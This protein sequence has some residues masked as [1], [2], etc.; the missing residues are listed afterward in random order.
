MTN[1]DRIRSMSDEELAE[2]L[3]SICPYERGIDSEP[4]LG[5]YDVDKDCGID[6]HDSY[7]D[8]LEWL[9]EERV[10]SNEISFTRA[11]ISIPSDM[12]VDCDIGEEITAYV[13]TWFD[14]DKKFGLDTASRDD[15]WVNVYAKFN[16]F[17]DTLRIECVVT[18][19]DYYN[20]FDYEPTKDEEQ[21]VKDM[22]TEKIRE[23]YGQTPKEYCLEVQN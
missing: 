19:D 14:V 10:L 1:A 20:E 5:I 21:L 16:P 13:E 8:L 23:V 12:D 18:G 2:L 15:E 6:V 17:K 22:I 3:Y 7:K 11:N 9:Q 4:M